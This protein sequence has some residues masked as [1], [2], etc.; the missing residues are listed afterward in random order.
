MQSVQPA[1]KRYGSH[2]HRKRKILQMASKLLCQRLLLKKLQRLR[3]LIVSALRMTVNANQKI[4]E[5]SRVMI[6]SVSRVN[7]VSL[8][9]VEKAVSNV[10]KALVVK[11]A[12]NKRA[13]I[14]MTD[15]VRKNTV[16]SHANLSINL[17][18]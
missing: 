14:V 12:A 10:R 1:Q 11:V 9:K 3:R 4:P 2:V 5:I 8:V 13:V 7:H 17:V 16:I 18:Q 6:N 15:L